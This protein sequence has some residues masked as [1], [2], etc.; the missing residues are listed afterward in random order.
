MA[1]LSA[2]EGRGVYYWASPLEAHM[3]KG[4]EVAL[5]GGG[6]SAGQA[7]V[8]LA[9][10]AAHVHVLIRR[11]SF[12]ATMSRYLIERIAGLPNVTVYPHTEIR[13]LEGDATGLASVLLNTLPE[14]GAVRLDVRHLFLFMGA[15]PNTDWLRT[16]GVELDD[17]GFVLTGA[18]VRAAGR[19][20]AVDATA[21]DLMTS[22]EGV[23]A[24][25][26]TR[27]G[28]MKR[29]ATAVGEGAAVVAQI[30]AWLATSER[31]AQ[32]RRPGLMILAGPV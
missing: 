25:G 28:S 19:R 14:G 26:D 22:V 7:I 10:Y 3:C 18:A 29:V 20:Q 11:E 2:L 5:V 8:F 12:E 15:D 13:Q 32:N 1:A 21:V 6:N 9:G 24:V 27:A 23:F 16:C 31:L 4:A 30:H 17:H